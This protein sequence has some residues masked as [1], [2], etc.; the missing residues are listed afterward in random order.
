M[1]EPTVTSY[2]V[3]S[4]ARTGSSLLCRG[5]IA[6]RVAGNPQEIFAPAS[7]AEWR[8]ETGVS[9]GE[10]YGRF[11]EAAKRYGTRDHVYGV[12]I[13]WMDVATLAHNIGFRGRRED[14]LEHLFPGALFVNIVRRDR[15]AQALSWF[16]ALET[17]EWWR[18]TGAPPVEPPG[19]D[20]DRVCALMVEIDRQ[21][22]EWLRYFH[23]RGITALSVEYE[24]LVSDRRGQIGRVLAFLGRDPAAAA[25]I[26]DPGMI[27]QADLVTERWRRAMQCEPAGT[28][29][30][31]RYMAAA[32][33]R[34]SRVAIAQGEPEEGERDAQ[35]ALACAAELKAYGQISDILECLAVL[36]GQAGRHREAA[37]LFGARETVRQRIGFKVYEADYEAS[38]AAL[39]NALGEQDFE[40]A[41]YEGVALSTEEAIAYAQRGRDERKRTTS[42]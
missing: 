6:S 41:W 18:W 20:P 36:A 10:S 19:L 27:R 25:A 37:R 39:R 12:K 11:V 38:V 34:R 5:L 2:V 22:S 26:P 14:V 9:R 32:L 1:S 13:H 42:G 24:E 28:I 21:Q 7:E 23:E 33:T 40:T 3:A 30:A 8:A 16:R 17:N 4:T 15:L 29:L 31:G 35:D